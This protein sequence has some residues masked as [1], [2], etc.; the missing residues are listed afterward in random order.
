MEAKGEKGRLVGMWGGSCGGGGGGYGGTAAAGTADEDSSG[1]AAWRRGVC[2][3][4][5]WKGGREG[6]VGEECGGLGGG[7]ERGR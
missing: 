6:R 3:E 1:L 7:G 2:I 5:W 4:R